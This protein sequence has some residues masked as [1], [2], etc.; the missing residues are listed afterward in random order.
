MKE[1]YHFSNISGMK[2]RNNEGG[3]DFWPEHYH[4]FHV[5]LV[6]L[7]VGGIYFAL[8]FHKHYLMPTGKKHAAL[9]LKQIL[10]N[11]TFYTHKC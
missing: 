5:F 3:Y 6:L 2:K 10:H 1:I 9:Q 4:P 8:W 7:C 11:I